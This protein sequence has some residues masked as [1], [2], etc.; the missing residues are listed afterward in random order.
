MS[1]E[2]HR[3]EDRMGLTDS[4]GPG[5]AEDNTTQGIRCPTINEPSP[6]RTCVCRTEV[7]RREDRAARLPKLQV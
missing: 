4:I 2:N 7:S 6:T 5:S 3:L 1:R